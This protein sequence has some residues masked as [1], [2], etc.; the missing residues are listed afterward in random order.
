MKKV[1]RWLEALYEQKITEE[2]DRVVVVLGDEG[3]GKSTLM[4][5]VYVLWR[6]ILGREID[7]EELLDR[8]VWTRQEYKSALTEYE[9]QSAIVVPDAAR[10]LYKKDAMTG[11]QKEIEKDMLQSRIQENLI[12]LGFQD[13]D[14]VPSQ[15]QDRRV[16]NVL[17]LPSRG[18][19]E[20]YARAAIDKRQ[21]NERWPTPDLVDTV[22][23]LDGTELWNQYQKLD[24]QKKIELMS[25]EDDEEDEEELTLEEIAIQISEGAPENYISRNSSNKTP[26]IDADLIEVDYDLSIRDAKKVKKLVERR[27]NIEEVELLA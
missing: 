8:L 10:I 12:L 19:V 2:F 18:K 25:T 5:Q 26:Y 7:N 13:W 15:F 4:M 24:Q 22:P 3:M 20:G 16:H 6:R 11:E 1:D 21:E 9:K 17:R 23:A 27:V 14:T